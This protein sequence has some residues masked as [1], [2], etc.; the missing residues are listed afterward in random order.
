MKRGAVGKRKL[1]NLEMEGG[2]KVNGTSIEV[3]GHEEEGEQAPG[4]CACTPFF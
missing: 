3:E 1:F 4:S 2:L